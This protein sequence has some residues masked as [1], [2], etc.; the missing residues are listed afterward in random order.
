[1]TD[2]INLAIEALEK[3]HAS[4]PSCRE[5]N[6]IYQYPDD[7]GHYCDRP[8]TNGDKFQALPIVQL[9]RKE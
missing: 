4:T 7:D 1:M 5:C 3:Y 2:P 9:Y 8:C 6:G